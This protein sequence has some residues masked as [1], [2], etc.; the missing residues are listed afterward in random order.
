MRRGV[1]IFSLFTLIAQTY[2]VDV[3]IDD[4][5]QRPQLLADMIVA[6]LSGVKRPLLWGARDELQI[7]RGLNGITM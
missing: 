3:V 7:T 5:Q 2:G 1:G 6:V 4:N